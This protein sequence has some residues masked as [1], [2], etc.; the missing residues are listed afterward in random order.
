MTYCEPHN[1]AIIEGRPASDAGELDR[2]IVL[3]LIGG[4]GTPIVLAKAN[5]IIIEN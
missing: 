3:L 2:V 5:L 1:H 4:R